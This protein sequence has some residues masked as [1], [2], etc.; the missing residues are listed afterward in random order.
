MLLFRRPEACRMFNL[1]SI[2]GFSVWVLMK[3][4]QKFPIQL[5]QLMMSS[6][7]CSP[8]VICFMNRERVIWCSSLRP[9]NSPFSSASVLGQA[10]Q[11]RQVMLHTMLSDLIQVSSCLFVNDVW[12][13]VQEF[14]WAVGCECCFGIV[15]LIL[16]SCD[17]C[18][19]RHCLVICA[20]LRVFL[21]HQ[22]N[23]ALLNR[24]HK[25][26]AK[27][28]CYAST[29]R[30]MLPPVVC[31]FQSLLSQIHVVQLQALKLFRSS[32]PS[33]CRHETIRTWSVLSS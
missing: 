19:P 26:A 23:E 7:C 6:S 3:K 4:L 30:A 17:V 25:P 33:L 2:L 9:R 1:Y 11:A 18:C 10:G 21:D 31:F 16:T 29:C 32:V 5:L 14:K 15:A 8:S 13:T 27:N 28:T 24:W 22:A 20:A 12:R